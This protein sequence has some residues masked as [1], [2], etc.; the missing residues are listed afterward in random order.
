MPT[1]SERKRF[2][3]DLDSLLPLLY[4]LKRRKK[5]RRNGVS[6]V[7]RDN[8]LIDRLFKILTKTYSSAL[9]FRYF[10]GRLPVPRAED[11]LEWLFSKVCD[12]R[13]KQETYITRATFLISV[14][15]L[16]TIQCSK[17]TPE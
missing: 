17:T 5:I 1:Y 12:K 3:R 11:R 13:F 9:L 2:L 7:Y 10:Y 14:V 15:K 16:E 8:F 4:I 6:K